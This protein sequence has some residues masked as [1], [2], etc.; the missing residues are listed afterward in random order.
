MERNRTG[1]AGRAKNILQEIVRKNAEGTKIAKE[2]LN[3][4]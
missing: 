1:D 2:W 3:K 4:W